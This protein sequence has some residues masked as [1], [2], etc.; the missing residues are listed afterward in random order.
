M[1][2]ETIRITEKLKGFRLFGMTIDFWCKE[3]NNNVVQY[4]YKTSFDF[5]KEIG[6]LEALFIISGRE[7]YIVQR[8]ARY[9]KKAY[10][11]TGHPARIARG[12]RSHWNGG[13]NFVI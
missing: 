10:M 8:F 4:Y 12:V 3:H 13:V 7:D 9:P 5:K 1:S 2:K 6:F 11:V